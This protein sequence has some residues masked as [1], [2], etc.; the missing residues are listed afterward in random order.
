[1]NS[2]HIEI[3]GPSA[4]QPRDNPILP[5]ITCVHQNDSTAAY[6]IPKHSDLYLARTW[7]CTSDRSGLNFVK[8]LKSSSA[9]CS[10]RY[11]AMHLSALLPS[12]GQ[13]SRTRGRFLDRGQSLRQSA[14]SRQLVL[15]GP[16]RYGNGKTPC[17]ERVSSIY[18]S[19]ILNTVR[20]HG[21]DSLPAVLVMAS[22]PNREMK[23]QVM[24]YG[25]RPTNCPSLLSRPT[26]IFTVTRLR[27]RRGS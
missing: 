27:A 11:H 14:K 4:E 7:Y 22:T 12:V 17:R 9:D 25:L 18:R 1:M 5:F 23:P 13:V 6:P 19:S 15:T 2:V 10:I 3:I 20:L 21:R 8:M 24:S 26:V 16:C